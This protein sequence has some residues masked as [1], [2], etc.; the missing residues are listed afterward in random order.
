MKIRK[1]ILW[2]TVTFVTLLTLTLTW[3]WTADLGIFKPR[4]ERWLSEETG[5]EFVIDGEFHVDL[6]RHC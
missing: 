2:S 5:R 6:T 1:T 3:L 4:L